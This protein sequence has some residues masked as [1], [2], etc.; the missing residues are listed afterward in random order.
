[1]TDINDV[2][3]TSLSHLIGQEHAKKVI[4]VGLNYAFSENQPFPTP[5]L[6]LGPP[7]IGK[8]AFA[9]VI[10]QEMCSSF[11]ET[12]AQSIQS[13]AD[14]HAVLLRARDKDVVFLDECHE[15][16]KKLQTL[17]YLA[18]D[19]RRI[20]VNGSGQ[21]PQSIPIADF[22]LLLATTD[23]QRLLQPL[24]DRAKVIINCDY[25]K[26]E[27]LAQIVWHRSR[28]LGWDVHEAVLPLIAKRSRGTPRIALR[29]LN[30]CWRC[31]RSEGEKNVDIKHLEQACQLEKIDEIGLDST[32]RR[33]LMALGKGPTRLGVIACILGLESRAVSHHVEPFLLRSGLVVKDKN[34][35][36][37]LTQQGYEYLSHS[38]PETD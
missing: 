5:T 16:D 7:G 38:R 26:P 11:T 33:Y 13:P 29:L 31:C 6:L 10:A 2:Q 9:N 1:M 32:E 28:A 20:V 8:T 23:P 12:L 27:E 3:P 14:M 19:K 21:S 36:R 34:G 24:K 4:E 25:Y 22:T 15:L 35:L 17:L 30:S 18:I 37:E